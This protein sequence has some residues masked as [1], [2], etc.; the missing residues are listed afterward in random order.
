MEPY[1]T[2][3]KYAGRGGVMSG[4]EIIAWSAIGAVTILRVA[5]VV[6]MIALFVVVVRGVIRLEP[7]SHA[8]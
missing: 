6:G 3:S 1:P 7:V 4:W 8:D 2:A 5:L